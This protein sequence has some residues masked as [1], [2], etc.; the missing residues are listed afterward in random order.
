MV[1]IIHM[2]QFCTCSYC[3]GSTKN[4]SRWGFQPYKNHT[5]YEFIA[6]KIVSRWGFQPGTNIAL[7]IVAV[8]VL[9]GRVASDI[10]H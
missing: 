9:S 8:S 3:T 1:F 4:V 10:V 6:K 5:V 2:Y 7:A